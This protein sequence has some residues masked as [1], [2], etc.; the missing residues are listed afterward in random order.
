MTG[1]RYCDTIQKVQHKILTKAQL[2]E[3]IYKVR[4]VAGLKFSPGM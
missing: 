1:V 2:Q 4:M 3:E